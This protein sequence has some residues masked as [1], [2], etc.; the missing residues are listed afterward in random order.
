M[1]TVKGK[2]IVISMLSGGLYYP[3]FCT[4]TADFTVNQ[5][6]IEM[7]TINSGSSREY[8]AGMMNASLTVTGVTTLDNTNSRVSVNYLEQQAI[9]RTTQSFAITMTDDDGNDLV[10]LFDGIIISTNFNRDVSSYSQSSVTIRVTGGITY[11]TV[12]TPPVP[13][14]VY[15][16]YFACVEGE[17]SISDA[18]L[19]GVDILQVARS[20]DTHEETGGVPGNHQFKYTTGTGTI[21]FDVNIPF[22]DGEVIYVEWKV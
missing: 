19:I 8:T 14:V 18:S 21:G 11:D 4:K 13:E 15:S 10:R 16:D 3:I 17:T 22:N 5:D 6:E 12:V 2:N 9:R 7:T 1:N 20:G